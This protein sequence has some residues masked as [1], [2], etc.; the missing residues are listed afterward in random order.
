[1]AN[2][3]LIKKYQQGST[4][5]P[6]WTA[7]KFEDL[8]T[9][10]YYWKQWSPEMKVKTDFY[11]GETLDETWKVLVD[12]QGNIVDTS[13][14]Q[15]QADYIALSGNGNFKADHPGVTFI[16]D[17]NTKQKFVQ[18]T[19][20]TAD[21]RIERMSNA[22]IA[23]QEQWEQIKQKEDE[24]KFT[25]TPEGHKI[26]L[27]EKDKEANAKTP[28]V[29]MLVG[30]PLALGVGTA[31]L[32]TNPIALPASILGARV[33]EVTADYPFQQ[34]GYR[35]FGDWLFEG[36]NTPEWLKENSNIG[37]W[38]GGGMGW[39][40]GKGAEKALGVKLLKRPTLL[41]DTYA[42]QWEKEDMQKRLHDAFL[43]N[44]WN[45]IPQAIEDVEA[46][47]LSSSVPKATTSVK[48]PGVFY[49]KIGE[50]NEG[51]MFSQAVKTLKDKFKKAFGNDPV[52]NLMERAG[53]PEEQR[54]SVEI[55][56]F[57]K[58]IPDQNN[59]W[60]DPMTG[61]RQ[62][63]AA[64]NMTDEEIIKVFS[65]GASQ[66]LKRLKSPEFKALVQ[67]EMGWG[68]TEYNELMQEINNRLKDGHSIK[69]KGIDELQ[70]GYTANTN[71]LPDGSVIYTINRDRFAATPFDPIISLK[72]SGAHEFYHGLTGGI[73]G[74]NQVQGATQSMLAKKYPRLAQIMDHNADLVKTFEFNEW[75]NYFANTPKYQI[76]QDLRN[77]GFTEKQIEEAVE[78]N[79]P[80]A[81][82]FKNYINSNQE[83]AARSTTAAKYGP[84]S[85]DY[86][87]LAQFY[88]QES[89]D[90]SGRLLS[91]VGEINEGSAS[92]VAT[93]LFKSDPEFLNRFKEL[94]AYT[95]LNGG[96]NLGQYGVITQGLPKNVQ[97]YIMHNIIGR[98][99]I[100]G[101]KGNWWTGNVQNRAKEVMNEVKVGE[102]PNWLFKDAGGGFE[103]QYN[104]E[105]NFIA[106]NVESTKFTP[107]YIKT[108][109]GD[110]LIDN[111]IPLTKE[112]EDIL[113]KALDED[114]LDLPNK[115]NAGELKGYQHMEAERTTTIHDAVRRLLSKEQLK[116]DI[117]LQNKLIDKLSD[118][119][120]FKALEQSNGYGR[121]YVEFLRESGGLTHKKANQIR[122]AMKVLCATGDINEGSVAG[123]F[124][125]KN[126][127]NRLYKARRTV[128]EYLGSEE[129]VKQ[130]MKSGVPKKEAQV[131]ANE[132]KNNALKVKHRFS[133][134]AGMDS[135]YARNPKDS[136]KISP[137]IK[138]GKEAPDIEDSV[139]HEYGGHA[140]T[141]G[142]LSD[143][144]EEQIN[145]Q[146]PEEW[147]N[148]L[149]QN[150]MRQSPHLLEINEHNL[151]LKPVRL[152]QFQVPDDQLLRSDKFLIDYLENVDEY[153]ARARAA[154]IGKGNHWS[155]FNFN[156]VLGWYFTPESIENLQNLV[157]SKVGDVNKGS[158][159]GAL[160][161]RIQPLMPARSHPLVDLFRFQWPTWTNGSLGYGHKYRAIGRNKGLKDA[162]KNGIRSKA[163]EY[164]DVDE[165]YW[166]QDAPLREYTKKSPLLLRY[167]K[168]GKAVFRTGNNLN[169]VSSAKNPISFWD[170]NVTLH[171]RWPFYSGYH[172][173][174]KT[175][176]GI[177]HAKMLNNLNRFIET[178]VRKT[179]YG[180]LY[181][182][183]FDFLLN[184][185]SN[186]KDQAE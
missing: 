78:I 169:P 100:A 67:K 113:V 51:S 131:I 8:P 111:T 44:Y 170:P 21:E 163:K 59:V 50:T 42:E 96:D 153:T 143:N 145:A 106:V 57:G 168:K 158:A 156:D 140:S 60:I 101:N 75:A 32:L 76:V 109:E 28:G 90:Q 18:P 3:K 139:Y 176:E 89:L 174:P 63:I 92:G 38:L 166:S 12:D 81:N 125:I 58:N 20:E 91:K 138:I 52:W 34:L 115:S 183:L 25:Q 22:P 33:G 172:E 7:D 116:W 112:Q 151:K 141:F 37:L 64:P 39:S 47:E 157:W 117:N 161:K 82:S 97:D 83:T 93:N 135:S 114:F 119:K 1:M 178:P 65:E 150:I 9:R 35:S 14:P 162:I 99:I 164:N 53:I 23:T 56:L 159:T 136:G 10:K 180:Y 79:I 31:V 127:L 184:R 173:I 2:K 148:K 45:K 179:A 128:E 182:K 105:K 72:S 24:E 48:R 71:I 142:L 137:S 17:K 86:D 155:K 98:R 132:M 84:D 181:Y 80:R 6:A 122:S 49:S 152:P 55:S 54:G 175:H 15:V 62:P 29:G 13:N 46:V 102:F 95:V 41:A 123:N 69:V 133:S 36:T 149:Y 120:I 185:R 73:R 124:D 68:D 171:G 74:T 177:K 107:E 108:H 103:G 40:I 87:D 43:N 154:N 77:A 130:I 66:Q 165:V 118:E 129:H 19:I 30:V 186:K 126:F 61:F 4:L 70:Q 110:H 88:T 146:W 160:K 167:D 16:F 27:H 85:G 94:L 121:R 134:Q 147:R 104:P 11:T 26:W 144:L 5:T